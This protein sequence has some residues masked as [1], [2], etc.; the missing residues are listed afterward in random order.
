MV[1]HYTLLIFGC[2]GYCTAVAQLPEQDCINAI[3][4]CQSAYYQL[5]SY[6]GI[7]DTSQDHIVYPTNTSC[8]IGGEQNS[9]WY[10]FTVTG[11]GDLEMEIEPNS[12]GD[13]YDWAIY[14]LTNSD[15]SGIATGAAPEVRCNYSAIP[16]ST[17]MSFPYVL[18]SVGAGGPNQCAPMNV[19]VGETYVL[20]INNHA[21]TLTGYTLQFSGTAVIYD[22]VP[23][24]PIA[25]APFTCQPPSSLHLT[26]S[27]P[28]RCNSIAPDGS[29]FYVLGPSGVNVIGAS[30]AT[31][32]A[33]NFTT[34]VDIQL[35]S[36]I[37][38]NGHYVLHFKIDDTYGNILLDNCG[39][40]LSYL[41]SVPFDVAL[42]DAQF[43]YTIKKTCTGDSVYFH[44]LSVGDTVNAWS[45]NLGNGNTST[46]QN[47]SAFYP[48]TGTYK[49]T[50]AITDTL[51]CF[52]NDSALVNAHVQPP[53]SHFGVSPGPYCAGIPIS[54]SDSSSGQQIVYQW[55][56]GNNGQTNLPDPQ[57]TYTTGGLF[58]VQL[59]VTDT[60]GC[61]DTSSVL[62][63]VAQPLVADFSVSPSA[64]C[65]GDTIT[66]KDGSTGTPTSYQWFGTGI[67]GDTSTLIKVV[68]SI[69][70]TYQF[71]LIVDN[72]SCNPD[73]VTKD[74]KVYDYPVVNL[75]LDT[76][77]CIDESITLNAENPGMFY[78]WSTG[79]NT[80]FITVS[81]V[82][83]EVWV[84]VDNN[85]CDTRD[86]IEVGSACPYFIPN[87]FTPNDDGLNDVFK[88]ITNGNQQFQFSIFNRWGQ[89]VFFTTDPSVGWDGTFNGKKEEMGVYVYELETVFSNGVKKTSHGNLTLIR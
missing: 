66:L 34:S 87:A 36:P 63:Q 55:Y 22:T 52:N 35:A 21:N 14:N 74:L 88:I 33:G 67:S 84:Q 60:I 25:L 59:I 70:G 64:L 71:T 49:I 53:I 51:G 89:L 37:T 13:D 28:V 12:P 62:L 5:N 40:E 4:V 75:G 16:G 81:K 23:P 58:Q 46:L 77:I 48:T 41:D 9:V 30:S 32:S 39:N 8:L 82:P 2:L 17:G 7:G 86:T 50:L 31:C 45:W 10:I 27:E 57:F 43:S 76:A 19:L 73:S 1:K 6:V 15:C 65:V 18:T 29:D 61:H 85:G 42:A 79:E 78:I 54:F 20:L 83:Q 68:Y 26:V 56:F 72:P 24:S 47:P 69:S 44:D 80:Q 11:A 38:V 3:P